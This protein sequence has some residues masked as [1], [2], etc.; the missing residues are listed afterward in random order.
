MILPCT[1]IHAEQDKLHGKGRRVHNETKT[2]ARC[3]VCKNE[4]PLT[5]QQIK[6]KNTK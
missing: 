5:S 3:T 1:C 2:S 6:D 4:K